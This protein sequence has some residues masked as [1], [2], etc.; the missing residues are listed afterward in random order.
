MPTNYIPQLN[1][2]TYGGFSDWRVPSKHELRSLINYSGINPA[3]QSKI[4]KTLVPQDY[5][6]G[7]T[8]DLRSDC[9]RVILAQAC[10]GASDAG[11][12]EIQI[13]NL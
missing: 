7:A 11:G 2:M 4:F 9:G 1:E 10:R 6:C 3:C 8:Y 5:W 12:A 13:V